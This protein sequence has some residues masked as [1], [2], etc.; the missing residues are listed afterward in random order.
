MNPENLDIKKINNFGVV[1]FDGL[2]IREKRIKKVI[3]ATM[4]A[5]L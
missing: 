4:Q 1:I 3:G 5:L 2:A